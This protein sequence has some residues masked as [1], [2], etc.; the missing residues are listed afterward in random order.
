MHVCRCAT[1]VSLVLLCVCMCVCVCA[2]VR[3]CACACACVCV[4]ARSLFWPGGDAFA[5]RPG[6]LQPH[7]Q[8]IPTISIFKNTSSPLSLSSPCPPFFPCL[9]V[10]HS[11]VWLRHTAA[12][13]RH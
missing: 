11:G 1:I 10:S 13:Q 4:R 9:H 12:P 8:F 6:H 7:P 5:R 2:C 3:A